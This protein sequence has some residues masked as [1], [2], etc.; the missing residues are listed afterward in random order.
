VQL[1]LDQ[2]DIQAWLCGNSAVL[3]PWQ[4]TLADKAE[5]I[6]LAQRQAALETSAARREFLL[7]LPHGFNLT[8][9]DWPSDTRRSARR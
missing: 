8:D 6:R 9:E 2:P 4:L 7:A 5:F 1:V 3:P